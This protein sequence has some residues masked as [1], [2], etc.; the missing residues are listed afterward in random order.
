MCRTSRRAVAFASLAVALASVGCQQKTECK[1]A[2]S[3]F[4]SDLELAGWD[5]TLRKASL[6]IAGRLPNNFE[7]QLVDKQGQAG[8]EAVLDQMMTEDPFYDR[9][10]EIYNDLLLTD[11]YLT[12]GTMILDPDR[13][14]NA[15]YFERYDGGSPDY[16]AN[17][18]GADWGVG[19]EPLNIIAHVVRNDRNFGEILAGDYTLVNAY[20]AQSYGLYDLTFVGDPFSK[21][22]LLEV[23]MTNMTHVG[24]MT[25]PS[26][27]NSFPTSATN[28]NRHRS[29]YIY[30]YFLDVDVMLLG[31]RPLTTSNIEGDTP[32]MNDPTCTA[33]H[34]TVD[35]LAGTFQN[36]DDQGF[37]RPPAEG[38]HT[39]M[40]P[41]GFGGEQYKASSKEE[42]LRWLASRAIQQPGFVR[43]AVNT[44]F[45]GLIGDP[46][47]KV[48]D[49]DENTPEGQSAF[50][51]FDAQQA[52]LREIGDRFKSSNY[53]MKT[54]VKGIILTPYF[55]ALNIKADAPPERALD[56]ANIGMGRLLTP[57]ML[58]R[59]IMTMLALDRYWGV[60]GGLEPDYYLLNPD[61]YLIYY[62]GI[63]SVAT[64]T[65]ILE[66]N[67]IQVNVARRMSNELACRAVAL[68][69]SQPTTQR[70]LLP[71]VNI[72]TIPE[73]VD[74]PSVAEGP[75]VQAVKA[76]ISYLHDRLLDE[77][78]AGG[79]D[80]FERTYQLFLETL[81]DGRDR[82][83][84]GTTA[85]ALPS[86]CQGSNDS[87]QDQSVK[88]GITKDPDYTVR[89][90][91]AV[92]SY[93]L[94]DYKFLYE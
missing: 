43:S 21:E 54:V 57:E 61:Q 13:F 41:P 76:N 34:A 9:L 24:L 33:C 60:P 51:A 94:A 79:D 1:A 88:G 91:M 32:T 89:A 45:T 83:S 55:R 75:A 92:V 6:S 53:N 8:V 44:M 59:K 42:P 74:D 46:P 71:K 20:S 11:R 68:D 63:D 86:D 5:Q 37:Y 28:R 18:Y 23:R 12:G 15:R 62:G 19:R 66:P 73:N 90:W 85:V 35:P 36:W 80:E 17:Q 72:N 58:H 82:L 3:P 69:L 77:R 2:C 70:A 10:K 25:T 56:Y 49:A 50:A 16:I 38:W 30:K 87:W 84:K 7:R 4:Y 65:R 40:F 78:V 31:V 93:M 52:V 14:P 48:P 26:F 64:T 47:L 81:R 27:L 22:N 67:G 29:R 39:D